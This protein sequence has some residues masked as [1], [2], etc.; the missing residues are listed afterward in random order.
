MDCNLRGGRTYMYFKG[1]PLYPFGYGLSD[2]TFEYSNLRA[3][4]KQIPADGEVSMT[5]DVRNGRSSLTGWM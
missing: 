1:K 5:V 3:S 2:T 4:A